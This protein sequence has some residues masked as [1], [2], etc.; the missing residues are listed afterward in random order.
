VPPPTLYGRDAELARLTEGLTAG[1][2]LAVVGEAGVGKTALVRA[3]VAKVGLEVREGGALET[4]S[5][6]PFLA[7]R[8]AVGDD[9]RGDTTA[10]AIEVE[11]RLGPQLLF[12]DDLQWTDDATRQVLGLLAARIALVTTIRASDPAATKVRE[13]TAA[14]GAEIM[15]LG[16]VD[17]DAA[18]AIACRARPALEGPALNLLIAEGGGNPLLLEELASRGRP[19]SSL[20]RAL[21]TRLDRLSGQARESFALLAVAG[22][23]LPAA[24][25]GPGAA[26]LLASGVAVVDGDA[27]APRHA[28]LAE[29][30]L[31]TL[32][33]RALRNIHDRLAS[34]IDDPAE[35]AQHLAGAGRRVEALAAAQA[36]A[37]QSATPTERAALLELVASLSIGPDA[38]SPRVAAARL[39][40]A[41]GGSG[42]LRAIELLEPIVE[43]PPELLLEREA[44]LG[45]A[46]WD[47]ADIAASRAA[48]ARGAQIDP[49]LPSSAAAT[50]AAG[51]VSFAL[52]VDGDLGAAR[53]ILDRAIA[54]GIATPRVVAV[55]ETI[56][57]FVDGLD[58]FDAIHAAYAELLSDPDESGA[59]FGTARNVAHV[60]TI[61]RGFDDA[62]AFLVRAVADFD[63][64]E[65]AGRADDLR[66]EDVQVLLFAGR[67]TEGLNLADA[68]L[69]RPLNSRT[70]DW[71]VIKRA[72]LLA[73]QG[74][75]DAATD[76]LDELASSVRSDYSGRG[77]LLEARIDV[78][79]W[80]GRPK[81][82]L[83]AYES[84]GAVPSPS[85]ANDIV[86]Q[87]DA[88]WARR[89]AGLDPGPAVPRQPWSMLAGASSESEG[90]RAL[91]RGEPAVAARW[92]ATARGAWA[93]F[94]VGRELI[95]HWAQGESLRLAGS[96]EAERV[97]H[98][99]LED[100]EVHGYSPIAA[101]ARRSLRQA[102]IR[103][104]PPRRET[105]TDRLAHM[106]GREREGLQLVGRGLTTPQIAR[107]MGLGRGT[108]DQI[109]GAATRKLGAASRIQAA[110][111]LAAAASGGRGGMR[112]LTVH[113]EAD[114]GE[115]V[116]AAL[117]GASILVDSDTDPALIEQIQDDLRRLGRDDAITL[118]SAM[119]TAA[120]EP[121]AVAVLGLLVE[122]MSL[123]EAASS[124]HL[125]RRT[126][127]RRL[128]K[129]R[130][131]LGV[132]TTAEALLAFQRRHS[133]G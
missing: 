118:A 112:I 56:R 108:V 94:H 28:L 66:G 49:G 46:Y 131:A 59:A 4:L 2:A 128:R 87:L 15:E 95:C 3:A 20:A 96:I 130:L 79:S 12:I 125:S 98:A 99:V 23:G 63:A 16:G 36:A 44:L 51:Q 76:I 14:V 34:L 41:N 11:R 115:V 62:H 69:E 17:R 83:D 8:R 121:D 129:A 32:D 48:Y 54:S 81:A 21:T 133:P 57:A 1:R 111:I 123:G 92:F 65:M 80:A 82:V 10:V 91:H 13:M 113:N 106:T 33:P 39:L 52:N 97:L 124:L 101:R 75:T 104:A 37:D 58:T 117:G 22:H 107:R 55:N 64:L 85:R 68:L 53:R 45:R 27:L 24:E 67:I 89:E 50:L 110:A 90:I 84:H 35:R 119:P 105:A 93:P 127:D 47:I 31:A 25:L 73:A 43:G 42:P 29:A 122:G 77:E 7:L 40:I 71:T 120:L 18:A 19:T 5:W 74:R 60:A 103:V 78:E 132:E 30:M 100:S 116:L 70:R 102:G 6:M 26:E 86:P 61:C 126:A 88:Q 9:L 109:L 114:A 72:Q 38:I